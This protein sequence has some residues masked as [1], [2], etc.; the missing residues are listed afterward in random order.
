MRRR[1]FVLA[2]A[3]GLVALVAPVAL[4][5]CSTAYY[6][7]MEKAGFAK[8]D[9]M[10]SRVKSARDAQGEA[11]REIV[12]ALEQFTRT[13]NVQGGELE[14]QYKRLAGQLSD[15][16]DA[17]DKVRKR[18]ADVADVADALFREWRAELA[19][20][21]SVELRSRSEQQL[22]QTQGR[23]QTMM[24]AMKQAESRLEPALR[25]LRDQVLY[26][27]HN[28]NARVLAGLKG[29]VARV[30]AE[31]ASLVTEVNRA[32]AEADRFIGTLESGG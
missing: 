4:S 9:I 18:V 31:V 12:S 6:A 21:S 3:A 20:Y 30:D 11:R 17:A 13:V 16:E 27:K 5:G 25:P 15:A 7:T 23:Y 8:R 14:A 10:A 1:A 28:L 29:E 2:G 26:L 24:A 19:Q 32:I 22:R